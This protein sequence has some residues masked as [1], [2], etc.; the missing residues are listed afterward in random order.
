[1]QVLVTFRHIEATDA[2]RRYAES[3][4][5]RARKF[6]RHPIEA[7]VV[8]SVAKRRHM[9]EITVTGDHLTLNAAEETDDLYSAIDLAM[10]KLERQIK[11]HVTKRQSRKQTGPTE[12]GF[13]NRTARVQRP[14]VKSERVAVEPMS[15]REA[16]ERLAQAERDFVVF[17][18]E[19]SG[20]LN[21]LY[22][23]KDGSFGLI[24]P[25]G[26]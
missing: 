4:V 9:A 16:L 3:K 20:M 14:R 8:L 10:S 7:H 18:N 17:Q 5:G 22:R 26:A 13:P 24:E 6:L 1:M 15:V 19:S 2:L 25:E 11:K 12:S 21:V 23:C